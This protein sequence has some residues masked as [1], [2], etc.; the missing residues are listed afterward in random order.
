MNSAD[1]KFGK[2]PGRVPLPLW[3]RAAL[4][5]LA[6]FV[7]AEAGRFLSVRDSAYVSFW[8]PAGL[9]VSVLL[10]NDRRAWPWL[11]LGAFP[12]NL[13]FDL[14]HG[15]TFAAILLFYCF[16]CLVAGGMR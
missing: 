1:P 7:F 13:I 16:E 14:I 12:A 8:L 6:Y 15:T 10:L 11:V 3:K 2:I 5:S 4:F 9:Y